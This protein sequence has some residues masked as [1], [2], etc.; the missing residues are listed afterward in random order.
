MFVILQLLPSTIW[1][2]SCWQ[3]AEFGHVFNLAQLHAVIVYSA[4]QSAWLVCCFFVR[5]EVVAK[6]L[7][8]RL[9]TSGEITQMVYLS[10]NFITPSSKLR[11][12]TVAMTSGFCCS[13]WRW[14]RCYGSNSVGISIGSSKQRKPGR[15]T[16]SYPTNVNKI[17]CSC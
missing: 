17:D 13:H 4:F 9:F 16:L 7:G 1:F 11:T 2:C 12:R 3:S 8:F 15:P 6:L 5:L 10:I 14:P